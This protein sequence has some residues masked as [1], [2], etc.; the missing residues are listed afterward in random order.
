VNS[1]ELSTPDYIPEVLYADI[2]KTREITFYENGRLLLE[3]EEKGV[4]KTEAKFHMKF[5]YVKILAH[6]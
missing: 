2:D 1:K 3:N 6:S 4:K 5:E